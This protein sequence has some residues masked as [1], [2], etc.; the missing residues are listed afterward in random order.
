M[1]H[2][3]N[4][5][6]TYWDKAADNVYREQKS[7]NIYTGEVPEQQKKR[8]VYKRQLPSLAAESSTISFKGATGMAASSS[9]KLGMITLQREKI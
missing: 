9:C 3:E 1:F 7:D 5:D 2:E 8:D 6:S 4:T